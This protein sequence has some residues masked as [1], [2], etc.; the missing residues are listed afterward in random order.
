M[1]NELTIGFYGAAGEVTGSR[2]LVSAGGSRV[3]LDCGLFQGHRQESQD[4]S[5]NIPFPP[6]SLGAVVLSH[7]HIDHSGSLPL[8]YKKGAEAPLWCTPAS[9]ELIALMLKDSARLQEADARFYNKIHADEGLTISPLYDEQDVE[10]CL[11]HLR[12]HDFGSPFAAAP[13]VSVSFHNAGHV[14]GSAMV[15]LDVPVRGGKRRILFTGDLGRRGSLLMRPPAPPQGVDTLLIES[16]YGGRSHSPLDG[17]SEGFAAVIRRVL[18]EKGKLLIPSFAL[19]R[20]QEIV[21]LLEKL[22]R[23]HGVPPIPLYVDSPMAVEITNIFDKSLDDPG[24]TS[25][26]RAYAAKTGDDPFGLETIH[27]VRTKEESQALN[28]KPG[29]MIILSASGMCEGGRIL[30]HLRNN[31]GKDTTTILFV[32]HQ[33]SGTLGRRLQ[34]GAKKAKIFGLE[35]EV[36]AKVETM[37][38]LSSHADREDILAFIAAMDPKPRRIFLVHG[39]PEEQEALAGSLEAAGVRGVARPKFGEVAALD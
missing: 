28:D 19:E 38:G 27:Y 5:R 10:R 12:T 11:S 34:E 18:L 36:W 6:E 3:L 17:L 1:D 13:G 23:E 22:R 20:T 33:A 37:P 24:F 29:P 14:L 39:D 35:H 9:R 25:S 31:I 2:H 16:T 8:L 4:K 30:H 7:A 32:G 21:Y 15:Q 26:F